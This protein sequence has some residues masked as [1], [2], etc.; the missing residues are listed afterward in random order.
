MKTLRLKCI[1]GILLGTTLSGYTALGGE[2]INLGFD[3]LN[4]PN[5][6]PPI[7]GPPI[8]ITFGNWIR[9]GWHSTPESAVGYN[10]TQHFFGYASIVD[11]DFRDTHFGRNIPAP[12]VGTFSLAVWPISEPVGQPDV[13][14]PYTLTQTGDVPLGSQSLRFLYHGNDLRVFLGGDERTLYPLPDVISGDPRVPLYHYFAVDVSPYAGQTVELRFDFYSRGY[15]EVWGD[16]PP[17]R[18]GEPDAQNH[19]L[20]DLSFSPLAVP[21]PSTWALLGLGSMALVW[22][23]RKQRRGEPH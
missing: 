20:D 5:S 10:Y 3:Q 17:R 18:P 2:F 11:R 23:T 13:Y 16:H 4:W 15:D 8:D 7:P 12:V 9:P 14:M 19:V 6:S 1:V 21:E 22:G